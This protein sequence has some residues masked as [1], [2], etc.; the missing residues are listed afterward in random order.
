MIRPPVCRIRRPA[1]FLPNQPP[2][3]E[4]LTTQ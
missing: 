4:V 2:N 1:S 3:Q